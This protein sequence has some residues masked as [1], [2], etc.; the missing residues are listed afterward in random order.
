MYN[1]NPRELL[2][3]VEQ[4]FKDY[5]VYNRWVSILFRDLVSNIIH[6]TI[7]HHL[8][9]HITKVICKSVPSVVNVQSTYHEIMG[10]VVSHFCSL[11]FVN[12]NGEHPELILAYL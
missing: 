11:L 12:I 9:N 2:N 7:I 3:R 8:F 1:T 5:I 6:F 10:M 4:D